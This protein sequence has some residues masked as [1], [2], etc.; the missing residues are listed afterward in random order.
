MTVYREFA[1]FLNAAK[2][3]EFPHIGDRLEII[4]M[5]DMVDQWRGPYILVTLAPIEEHPLKDD[6]I[7]V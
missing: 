3:E 6:V 5:E 4:K 2:P 7:S 1:V